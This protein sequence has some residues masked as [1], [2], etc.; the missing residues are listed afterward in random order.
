MNRNTKHVLALAGATAAVA[1]AIYAFK[2]LKRQK[3]SG[4]KFK[5]SIIIDRPAADLYA[6]W[7]HFGNLARIAD[8]LES[9]QVLD[10]IRSRWTVAAPGEI[11][12]QWDAKITRDVKDEMIGWCS[13]EGS[14]IETAG[15]V[16]FEP[17]S[18]RRGTLVRVAF[19]YNLPA[20]KIGA[21]VASLFGKRPS[22]HVEDLLRRFKQIMETGEFAQAG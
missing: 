7:R 15:Y 5:K 3:Y 10:D 22:A 20:G 12:V 13:I 16:K 1:G 6:F 19:E 11:P 2:A 14:T 9:V 4:L 18:G 21:A 8:I 17:A